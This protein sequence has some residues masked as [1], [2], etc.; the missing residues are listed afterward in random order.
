LLCSANSSQEFQPSM[1]FLFVSSQ[2]CRWLPK[3][4]PR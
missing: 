2:F 3:A 1:M 4:A